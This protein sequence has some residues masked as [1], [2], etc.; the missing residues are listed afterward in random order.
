M[1]HNNYQWPK[2]YQ[3]NAYLL[4]LLLNKYSFYA[5]FKQQLH[6]KNLI[7]LDQLT[8][9]ENNILLK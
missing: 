4:E 8:T 9:S 5:T 3:H 7:Y 1:A 6:K 2:T